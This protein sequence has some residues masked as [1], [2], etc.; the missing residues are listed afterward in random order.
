MNPEPIY[1]PGI[2]VYPRDLEGLGSD[3]LYLKMTLVED[4]DDYFDYLVSKGDLFWLII[5]TIVFQL[6]EGDQMSS[7]VYHYETP[8]AGGLPEI[9]HSNVAFK[10]FLE[11]DAKFINVQRTS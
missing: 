6:K 9:L 3:P 8:P 4:R 2:V 10:A 7:Y 1:H 11:K 5:K